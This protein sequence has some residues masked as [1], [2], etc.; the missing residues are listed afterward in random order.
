MSCQIPF[1]VVVPV[2]EHLVLTKQHIVTFYDFAK[3][4]IFMNLLFGWHQITSYGVVV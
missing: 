4:S 2:F 1:F 3:V